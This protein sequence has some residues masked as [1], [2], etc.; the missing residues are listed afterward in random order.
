MFLVQLCPSLL[1]ANRAKSEVLTVVAMEMAV[2]W[3]VTH[4]SLVGSHRGFGG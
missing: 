2:L 4:C 1:S 3:D